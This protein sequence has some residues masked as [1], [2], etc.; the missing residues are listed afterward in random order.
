MRAFHN[1]DGWLRDVRAALENRETRC[2]ELADILE[3]LLDLV[4]TADSDT[5]VEDAD[6]SAGRQ[7]ELDLEPH[8]HDGREDLGGH[9][10]GPGADGSPHVVEPARVVPPVVH[11]VRQLARAGSRGTAQ[12]VVRPYRVRS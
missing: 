5:G 11:R 3:E 9:A 12:P 6:A 8:D 1:L 10:Q 7:C 4:D 2:Y